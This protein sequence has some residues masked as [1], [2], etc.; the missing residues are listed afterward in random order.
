MTGDSWAKLILFWFWAF[1]FGV[2]K[3]AVG[4]DVLLTCLNRAEDP[5]NTPRDGAVQWTTSALQIFRTMSQD[6]WVETQRL[7]KKVSTLFGGAADL[8]R[9]D[10]ASRILP[11]KLLQE[12]GDLIKERIRHGNKVGTLIPDLSK[13]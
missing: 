1:P 7:L 3:E 6:M 5:R 2:T 11:Y 10:K 8:E 9:A 12:F 4:I 13:R